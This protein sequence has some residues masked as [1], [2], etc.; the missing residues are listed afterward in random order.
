MLWLVK[1]YHSVP[2]YND[3]LDMR[4]NNSS[5]FFFKQKTA[6]EIA[7]CLVGSE[8]CIRD[9]S[10]HGRYLLGR[11]TELLRDS[12]D[13]A[14]GQF[15]AVAALEELVDHSASFIFQI[16]SAYRPSSISSKGHRDQ[17]I[18]R[19]FTGDNTFRAPSASVSSA[20]VNS[21]S[22]CY[23][24]KHSSDSTARGHQKRCKKTFQKK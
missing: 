14:M 8:M 24:Q 10:P 9:R 2:K 12:F 7:S 17:T 11:A 4:F 1:F 20:A 19:Q 22:V 23:R 6:Y 18:G 5:I 3:D 15:A 16:L 13:V 21:C